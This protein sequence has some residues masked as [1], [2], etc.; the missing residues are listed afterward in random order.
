MV[1]LKPCP[2]CG[3]EKIAMRNVGK[4]FGKS[5]YERTYLYMECRDCQAQTGV[6]GT[7]PKTIEAWNRRVGNGR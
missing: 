4:M 1:E 7:K 2:F 6:Y 3:S 5:A